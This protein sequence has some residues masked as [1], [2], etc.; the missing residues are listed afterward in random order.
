[1]PDPRTLWLNV[2]NVLLGL[3][4][5]GCIVAVAICFVYEFATRIW[6][7]HVISKELNHDMKEWFGSAHPHV[8]HGKH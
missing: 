4:I 3:V 7:S 5:L 6:R 1:M 2:A 8:P